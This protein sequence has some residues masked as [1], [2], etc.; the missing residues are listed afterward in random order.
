M[1]L[2]AGADVNAR[3]MYNVTVL[4]YAVSRRTADMVKMVLDKKPKVDSQDKYGWTALIHA[5]LRGNIDIVQL[6]M[7]AGADVNIKKSN[8]T[9]LMYARDGDKTEIVRLLENSV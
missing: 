6:L 7:E 9:A 1:L 2:N 4:I 8:Y 5:F 3:D